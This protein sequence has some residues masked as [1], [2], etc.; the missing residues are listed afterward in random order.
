MTLPQYAQ[1]ANPSQLVKIFCKGSC[2]KGRWAEMIQLRPSIDVL[3]QAQAF[4]YSARCLACGTLAN[5][6]Y[7]WIE[8]YR[9]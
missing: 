6:P 2:L 5:D 9:P 1:R 4:E 3:R 8:C 7:N